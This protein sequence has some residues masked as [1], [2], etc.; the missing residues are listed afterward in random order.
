MQILR[1][2][3]T[4]VD[5][6]LVS[7][8]GRYLVAGG[9]DCHVWDLQNPKAKPLTVVR[10]ALDVFAIDAHFLSTTELLIHTTHP[11]RWSR[12]DIETG[13][14]ID[15]LYEPNRFLHTVRV[16]PS[17]EL[18]KILSR[19]AVTRSEKLRTHRVVGGRLSPPGPDSS[20]PPL[21]RLFGFTP[22]GTHYLA[23]TDFTGQATGRHHL[24]DTATDG[25]VTTFARHPGHS[26]NDCTWCFAPRGR[27]LYVV[28]SRHLLCYDC[29]AGGLPAAMLA[30]PEAEVGRCPPIAAHPD[31]HILAT[32]EDGRAVTFRD[33]DTL[34]VLRTY[35]FAMPTVTCVAFTPDG[36]RCVIGN[37]RGKVLLFDVD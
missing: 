30:L 12:H 2:R 4:G 26:F 21:L 37:S 18:L 36:T 24:C 31:G 16:H 7:S 15:L 34:Q 17:G 1:G 6:L 10:G 32:V 8:D 23:E 9:W 27:E 20:G 19:P 13:A 11:Q 14:T 28:A 29:A 22:A 33:A 35:D 25:V 5:Q 3:R